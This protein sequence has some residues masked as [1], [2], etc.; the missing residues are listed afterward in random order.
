MVGG[1]ASPAA[2]ATNHTVVVST[3]PT[4]GEEFVASIK[5]RIPKFFSREPAQSAEMLQNRDEKL[6]GESGV[7][8]RIENPQDD[9]LGKQTCQQ[10][11][12]SVEDKFLAT[13]FT[14]IF[15]KETHN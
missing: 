6:P 5:T 13:A 4:V 10:I 8:R 14:N 12:A 2:A 1:F 15:N 11:V 3:T 7:V 9:V